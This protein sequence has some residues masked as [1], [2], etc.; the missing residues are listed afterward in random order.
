MDLTYDDVRE[1]LRVF[2]DSELRHLEV[3][4]GDTRLVADK[5]AAPQPSAA[6]VPRSDAAVT[7]DK[8]NDA[9]VDAT[10]AQAGPA[11]VTAPPNDGAAGDGL[12]AITAPVVGTF[13]RAPEPGAPPFVSIGDR[14]DTETTVGLIEVMKVFNSVLAQLEGEVAAVVVDDG[15]LVEYGQ[16]LILVK[17]SPG[18]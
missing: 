13:Y 9:A 8:P 18:S 1:L 10:P 17:P 3:V 15:Q 7:V 4:I 5:D 12:V 11:S 6:A 14:I 16:E 2:A